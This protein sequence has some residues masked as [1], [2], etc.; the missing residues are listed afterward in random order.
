MHN[1][2]SVDVEEWFQ[3]GAFEGVIAREDWPNLTAR[4][5]QN[6]D[7]V[8]HMFDEAGIKATFFTLAWI[9][10]R[11]PALVR[12]IA[13]CGH[14]IA[15]HGCTHDRVFHFQP[16][17]F[18]MDVARSKAVLEDVSGQEVLGYRAPSFSIDKRSPWAHGLLAEAG[19]GYSSSVAPI[20]HDHYG[21]RESPRFAWK[22]LLEDDFIELPV[23]TASVSGRIVPAGGGGFFRAYPYALS[24]ML[25]Q[26]I[27]AERRPA[28]FYFHPW[29]ID[30]G[31]PFVRRAPFKS[32]LRHYLNLSQMQAKLG[33]LLKDLQWT[34]VD[35][36]V[37][38]ERQALA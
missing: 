5:E 33:R 18:S 8:L 17:E 15:S 19:Y 4:I 37:A 24:R 10:E 25:L 21:W 36:I 11:Y 1:A 26:R 32:R 9:A 35:E 30:P 29:E 7:C 27:N 12:R 20:V 16:A 34:R 14:E 6:I 31:Q 3:V 23:S 28:I 22:P 13:D 38:Q 2:M